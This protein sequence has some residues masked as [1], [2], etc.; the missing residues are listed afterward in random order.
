MVL[1][2]LSKCIFRAQARPC[3][4][5]IET[6][7]III[8]IIF[9]PNESLVRGP[10]HAQKLPKF[11]TKFSLEGNLR[12]KLLLSVGVVKGPRQGPKTQLGAPV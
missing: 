10:K 8:I 4:D 7:G 2:S 9:S 6:E 1:Q 3:E 11:G 5:P 12:M